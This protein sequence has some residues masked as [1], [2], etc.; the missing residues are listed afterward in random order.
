[1]EAAVPLLGLVVLQAAEGDVPGGLGQ[2]GQQ[3]LGLGPGDGVPHRQVGVVDALLRVGVVAQHVVGHGV[4][5]GAVL[6]RHSGDGLLVPGLA[7]GQD[8]LV[9]AHHGG[10]PPLSAG[11][12]GGFY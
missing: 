10:F 3:V 4:A 11:G 8:F 12:G 7:Q 2:V 9:G 1:M 5:V 6:L